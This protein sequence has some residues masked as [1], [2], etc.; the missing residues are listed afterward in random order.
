MDRIPEM[1]AF[2]LALRQILLAT[3]NCGRLITRFLERHFV[4]GSARFPVKLA[5]DSR[6]Q[7]AYDLREFRQIISFQQNPVQPEPIKITY[8]LVALDEATGNFAVVVTPAYI[9]EGVKARQQLL[10]CVEQAMCGIYSYAGFCGGVIPR[11]NLFQYLLETSVPV[12]DEDANRFER[13][14]DLL[15]NSSF[16]EVS[17]TPDWII[18]LAAVLNPELMAKK[19]VIRTET[20]E[21]AFA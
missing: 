2:L 21:P 13:L 1:T 14:F 16:G 15:D 9:P 17:S 7:L 8:E 6:M 12:P 20:T 11:S 10:S 19:N 3:G 18:D 5:F 4:N